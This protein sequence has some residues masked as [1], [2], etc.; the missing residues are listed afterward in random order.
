VLI[1]H[2]VHEATHGNLS[3]DPRV[4]YWLQVSPS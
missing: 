4:N 3:T 1:A 2:T